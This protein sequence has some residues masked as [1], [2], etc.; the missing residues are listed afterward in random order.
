MRHTQDMRMQVVASLTKLK[1]LGAPQ[2]KVLVESQGDVAAPVL[3]MLMESQGSV[4]M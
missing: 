4:S 3:K 2:W 1:V